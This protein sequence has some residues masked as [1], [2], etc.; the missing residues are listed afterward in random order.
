MKCFIKQTILTKLHQIETYISNDGKNL[1]DKNISVMWEE[2]QVIVVLDGEE[3]QE[4]SY[5]IEY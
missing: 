4:K 1:S 3:Q 2:T 5:A